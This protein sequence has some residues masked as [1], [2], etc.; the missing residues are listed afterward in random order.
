MRI[1]GIDFKRDLDAI[2]AGAVLMGVV[3]ITP[4]VGDAV[5]GAIGSIRN[6]VSG[7]L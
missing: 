4:V 7:L 6:K 1:M 3:M 2:V 5:S